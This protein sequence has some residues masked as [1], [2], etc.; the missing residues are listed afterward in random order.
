MINALP[1]ERIVV[2][3]TASASGP[4]IDAL[5]APDRIVITATRTGT[6]RNETTFPQFLIE[7]FTSPEADLDKDGDLSVREVFQ[8]AAEKTARS[9]TETNHLA[10]EHA[11]LD[12][13]GDAQ[14]QRVEDL[15]AA[16]EGNLAGITYLKRRTALL[17]TVSDANRTAVAGMLRDKEALE[18]DIATLKS[19]K[20]NLSE[21]RYYAD[22]EVL[23]VRLAR[24]NDRIEEGQ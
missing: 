14:G 22:L 23:F 2:I 24:L 9:F 6:Q 12:D 3:N 17:A 7:A 16:A 18:R 13:T 21:D 5:S 15:E 1:A 10:T 4:F 20:N 8:Y 11:L 19:R